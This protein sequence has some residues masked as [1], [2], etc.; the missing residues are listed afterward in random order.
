ME[1][2][3]EI[4]E[5]LNQEYFRGIEVGKVSGFNEGY[6]EGYDDGYDIGFDKGF[7]K[8]EDNALRYGNT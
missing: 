3:S 5:L 8:G 2:S 7:E 6:Q 4:Q 1:H